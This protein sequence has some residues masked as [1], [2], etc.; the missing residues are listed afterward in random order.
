MN[1]KIKSLLF[2]LSGNLRI[3]TKELGKRIRATQQSS[4]YLIKQMKKRK[5]IKETAAIVDSV[6]LG[7]TNV[8]VGLNYLNF[9]ADVRKEI[10]DELKSNESIIS[11]EEARQGVDIIIE[12]ASSNLS[13]FNKAHTE[14]I[15][16]FR[17]DLET[18][19]IFPV[20]VKHKYSKNY[21]VRKF[22]DTD[23]ILCGDRE[24]ADLSETESS[25]LY[26][27]VEH[28]EARLVEIAKSAGISA[29][30]ALNIK[31]ALEIKAVIR[32]YSCILDNRKLGITRNLLF[33]RFSSSGIMDIDKLV[34]HARYN[35]N[36]I[37]LVKIIGE[38]HAMLVIESIQETDTVKELRSMF[39]IEDYFVVDCE[40]IHKKSY[41]PLMEG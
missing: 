10:M 24:V 15:H 22:N 12:Y 28:P 27:L 31:K 19:F 41:L 1:K 21:L 13:A 3:T 6:K 30:S 39:S 18:K 29:K 5:L 32:G 8:I 20:M 33:L 34:K 38:F 37:E 2:E 16:K 9:D 17:K 23:I 40:T 26:K 25:V 36:I 14:L 35:R 4:S 11:I 7:F